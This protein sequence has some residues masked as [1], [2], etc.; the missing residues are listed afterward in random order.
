M[1]QTLPITKARE[2]LTELVDRA[3]RLRNE[4]TITVNGEPKAV[5][6]SV[7]EYESLK[8][9]LEILSNTKLMEDLREAEAQATR[10]ELVDWEDF[11]EEMRW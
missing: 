3:A 9:T 10:G 1:T 7:D 11:K 2:N 4:Y 6:L 5:L 8:E